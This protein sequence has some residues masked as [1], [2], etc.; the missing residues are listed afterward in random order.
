MELNSWFL[1]SE[2]SMCVSIGILGQVWYLIVSIPNFCTLTYF[3][4]P[5]ELPWQKVKSS[6]IT[7]GGK[8]KAI[9]SLS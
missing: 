6:S 8:S 2:K 7:L 9:A 1:N 5:L 3:A 4:I